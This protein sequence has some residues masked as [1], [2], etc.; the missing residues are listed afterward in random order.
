MNAL[1][2]QAPP[3]SL[4]SAIAAVAREY[5]GEYD[6]AGA[7]LARAVRR[8][9]DAY[10]RLHGAPEDAGSERAALCARLKFF[11]PRDFPK[12][13]AP[14][15][16]LRS[17]SALPCPR[18]LRVLDLGAGLGTS[19]LAAAG[20]A[21]GQPGVERVRIEAVD[22]DPAA[23]ALAS[24][25]GARWA[26]DAGL[27]LE[28]TTRCAPLQPALLARLT[29]PYDLILLGFVL[30]ELA[31]KQPDDAVRSHHA[32]LSRLA[33]LLS[34]QGAIV[35]L[36]PALREH[37]RVLQQVR[38]LFASAEG[39]PYVFAPCLHAGACPLLARERDWCHEQLPLALPEPLAAI[40]R[41]A[42]LRSAQLSYSYLTLHRA[43]RSLAELDVLPAERVVSAP[44]R[45]KGK[46]ELH[47]CGAGAVRR[48]QRLDRHQ[49]ASNQALAGLGRGCIVQLL[50][51]A[52]RDREVL[53]VD[54]SARVR[55]LQSV[56]PIETDAE[57][58]LW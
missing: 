20:L 1:R 8:V 55:V 4:L 15:G 36:E 49:S 58:R 53:R 23:L 44:L 3:E 45:S 5:F 41:A 51:G 57:R 10:T 12:L 38:G 9:S 31:E 18:V 43:R 22:H 50:T 48:L 33:T 52:P 34:E 29:G 14:L 21:L 54:E 16:E 13:E 40:A 35:V 19:G 47:V 39:P 32:L 30:N 17:V 2:L 26:R 27:A 37:S 25:L 46:L 7:E 24:L 42:G 56:A 28:L 6:L 11:L